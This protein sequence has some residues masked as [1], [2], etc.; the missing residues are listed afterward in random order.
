MQCHPCP[1]CSSTYPTPPSTHPTPPPTQTTLPP[2]SPTQPTLPT[3]PPTATPPT[4]LPT[5]PPTQPTPPSHICPPTQN[6]PTMEFPNLPSI[7]YSTNCDF[8]EH[9]LYTLTCVETPLDCAARCATDIRC[10]HFTYIANL[11]GGTCHL[12]K[13]FGSGGAWASS[14]S[15]PSA[16]VCGYVLSRALTDN[17]LNICVG[18]DITGT[19]RTA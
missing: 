4:T 19:I 13:A 17:S 10:S 8:C 5:P 9:D 3:P 15:S 7:T 14:V 16:H 1:T 12:K 6:P 18:L 11:K 2:P